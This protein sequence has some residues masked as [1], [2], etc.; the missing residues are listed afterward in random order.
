MTIGVVRQVKHEG[1][2]L[3]IQIEDLGVQQ[4]CFDVRVY[5]EGQVLFH[6]KVA[7]PAAPAGESDEQR[8]ARLKAE[9]EK[10]FSTLSESIRR[11]KLKGGV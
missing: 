5:E 10:L 11:G 8:R 7:H 9:T 2:K 1:R 3:H 6:K 4:G